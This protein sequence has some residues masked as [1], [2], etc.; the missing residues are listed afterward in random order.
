MMKSSR[1]VIAVAIVAIGV[2][3][4]GV[5]LSF[6]VAGCRGVSVA[7]S[8][9]GNEIV[10][11]FGSLDDAVKERWIVW[12]IGGVHLPRELTPCCKGELLYAIK[13]CYFAG[14][15]LVRKD[16][17]CCPAGVFKL[18]IG[19]SPGPNY[20]LYFMADGFL[21]SY[22]C[23]SP[24]DVVNVHRLLKSAVLKSPVLDFE[25]IEPTAAVR[26]GGLSEQDDA[27]F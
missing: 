14:N 19:R 26:G 24:D 23:R 1:Q 17:V 16:N 4:V 12:S 9:I 13:D 2:I 22:L 15:D 25:T 11:I 8:T 27:D 5:A 21:L 18:E 7:H 3:A 20:S 6:V 10:E